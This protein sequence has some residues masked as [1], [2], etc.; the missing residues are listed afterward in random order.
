MRN[1]HVSR[2]S[3]QEVPLSLLG[4]CNFHISLFTVTS[5]EIL[6]SPKRFS[7]VLPSQIFHKHPAQTFFLSSSLSLPPSSREEAMARTKHL[8]S[9]SGRKK[10]DPRRSL[11][12]SPS[13]SPLSL[14]LYLP[15]ST[16]I[17]LVCLFV[18]I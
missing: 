17:P 18:C 15:L 5:R 14:Y 7:R 9:K 11:G 2:F 8:T 10:A 3:T 12:I 13:S 6:E 1:L 4:F 16:S